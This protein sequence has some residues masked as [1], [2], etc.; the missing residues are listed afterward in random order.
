MFI[1]N[2]KRLA[3]AAL[4]GLPMLASAATQAIEVYKSAT[5]G[6]CEAWVEHLRA[7]GFQVNPHNVATPSDMRG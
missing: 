6:C 1:E 3:A 4:I 7:N 5:C 2:A